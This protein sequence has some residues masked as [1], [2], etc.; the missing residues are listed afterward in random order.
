[1]RVAT[2]FKIIIV[3]VAAL[4]VSLYAIL[5][6]RDFSQY[7]GLI[8][9]QARAATGREL[10][11][12]GE[13]DLRLL[14]L[15][16]ALIVD[17]VTLKNAS[18]GTRPDMVTLRR[19][20]AE[21]A[22]L[23]LFS[24]NLTV[25]RLVLV[26]P[27]IF[28]ETDKKGR[29]NWIFTPDKA[30]PTP[31]ETPEDISNE[32]ASTTS[33]TASLPV[34]NEARI[35]NAR[36]TFRDGVT[37]TEQHFVLQ[38]LGAHARDAASP[39]TLEG[40]GDVD[41]AAFDFTARLGAPSALLKG[42]EPYG[43]KVT[44]HAGG[45]ELYLDGTIKEPLAGS[46]LDIQATVSG[47]DLSALGAVAGASLPALG[48]YRVSG[49]VSDIKSGYGLRSLEAA[50]GD[51]D[52]S[53]DLTIALGGRTR[54]TAKLKSRLLNL[55][56]FSDPAAASKETSEEDKKRLFSPDPLP[57]DGLRGLDVDLSLGAERLVAD[58]LI[59]EDL[60]LKLALDKGI[61]VLRPLNVHLASGTLSGDLALNASQP[62]TSLNLNVTMKELD[63]GALLSA[64]SGSQLLSGTARAKLA[65]RGKGESVAALMAGLQGK[66]SF[67]M[68]KGVLHDSTF[69]LLSADLLKSIT[70]WAGSKDS[71]ALNCAVSRFDIRAGMAVSQAL[72]VD[73]SNVS[74]SGEGGVNL[75]SEAIDITLTPRTR[76]LSLMSLAVPIKIGGTLADPSAA[77]DMSAVVTSV[78]KGVTKGVAVPVTGAVTGTAGVV[79]DIL[80][81]PLGLFGDGDK[82][83][84]KKEQAAATPSDDLC[85]AAI[86]GKKPAP[87]K[88]TTKKAAPKQAAPAEPAPVPTPTEPAPA[89]A[90]TP[91]PSSPSPMPSAPA[92]SPQPAPGE[93]FSEDLE[94]LGEG[95]SK[96]LK[97][98]FN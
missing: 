82:K 30:A 73:T 80:T 28:L 93:G 60:N 5:Q 36:L 41:G 10:V 38:H 57:L 47:G 7:R 89:P 19:L 55:A 86:S 15:S 43:V 59:L 4:V 34:V 92:P 29:G 24:G 52:L 97:G 51:S 6:S 1:M 33:A 26:A 87:K 58:K 44:A 70:P 49:R 84:A 16:P 90:P 64:L 11:L 20:E 74:V 63:M 23:P 76:D 53:G 21:V 12:A 50:L 96:G 31:E 9:E 22:L 88:T 95:L 2:L 65:L 48:P 25:K 72:L 39:L 78:V 45:A 54:L 91:A 32:D 98:L 77:P 71:N 42:T 14:S 66:T 17:D 56:D 37:E 40:A 27:E 3:A 67:V 75:A 79:G 94:G 68:E 18:W 69:D 8:E 85:Q 83:A 35:E 13:L 46:G 62:Q 81:A 61:L